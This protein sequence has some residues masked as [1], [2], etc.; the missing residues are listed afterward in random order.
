[1]LGWAPLSGRAVV[2]KRQT[3]TSHKRLLLIPVSVSGD[4]RREL[5]PSKQTRDR[6]QPMETDMGKV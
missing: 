6:A 1:M 3:L 5:A 4:L 2:P